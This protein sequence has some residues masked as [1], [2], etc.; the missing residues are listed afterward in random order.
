MGLD[1][2][3]ARDRSLRPAGAAVLSAL[4]ADDPGTPYDRRAAVY[5]RLVGS[6]AYNRL[7]WGTS[8]A[9]Y[10]A[11]AASA[12]RAGEGPLLDAACGSAVFTAEVYRAADRPLVLVDRSLGML[13]RA[14]ERFGGDDGARPALVQ[15][16]LLALPFA[17]GA[18][19]T[20]AC[21]GS[22][23]V[24]DDLAG[25]LSALRAQLA[26]GGWVYASSLVAETAVGRRYLRLLHRAGEVAAP[27]REAEVL[28]AAGA[29]LSDVTLRRHGS[30]A[31]VTGRA[32]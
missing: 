21:H 19:A 2:L 10:A 11:F 29:E 32:A 4:P 25:V 24:F 15:A 30:L 31:V 5:D 13:A 8:P 27:R 14:A 12:V 26:P 16:D 18:F 7:L 9:A 20:V 3:L 23:H 22:L 17:R 28:Q 6:G 1:E